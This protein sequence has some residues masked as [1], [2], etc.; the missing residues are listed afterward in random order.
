MG[1]A[2]LSDPIFHNEE[3]AR[4]HFEALR[5]P[6]GRVCPHC[7]TVDNSVLLKG[8]STRPG[9]YKC[10]DCRKP[11]TATLGTVYEASHIPLHKW[12]LATHLLCAS[13]KGMSAAQLHRE[14]GFGS[15]RSAWF[16][17]HRIRE[18]MAPIK[19]SA[20]PMGGEGKTIE[21]D[22]T[23]YGRVA[24]PKM[25]DEAGKP[26]KGSRRGR[27]PANK[28]AVVSLVERGGSVRSFHVETANR[29]TVERIVSENVA[30]ESR[31]HTDESH[32]YAK[33]R[34]PLMVAE[35]SAVKHSVGEYVRGDVHSNSVEGFYSIF[36]RGMSGVYQ[37][38]DEKH[39][40]RYLREF[41]FRYNHRAALGVNDTERT[42]AA[43]AGT[44]G[45]RLRYDQPNR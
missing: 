32:L 24:K 5:W 7:G 37:K 8:K 19:G 42:N 40:H 29:A 43:I 17:A 9:L 33:S 16:M 34:V 6:N 13:K 12:L 21:A 31:L 1:K 26:F 36:K 38:C 30:K 28:N 3:A 23:Y 22:E 39:L 14:L 25:T 20:D 44:V 15:Y 2:N 4:A 27:G 45:K 10:R 35:H 41:D 18:A 11:F